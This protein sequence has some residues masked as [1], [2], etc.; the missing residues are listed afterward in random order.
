MVF[1]RGRLLALI[2][3][4]SRRLEGGAT[5]P[6]HWLNSSATR[7]NL[8]QMV[9]SARFPIAPW[10][11]SRNPAS[12]I[13]H[14]TARRAPHDWEKRYQGNYTQRINICIYDYLNSLIIQ[15]I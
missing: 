8:H 1:S 3:V 11:D 15:Y 2:G 4:R 9:S 13:L 7:K 6:I 12:R 10:V 5:G 14:D